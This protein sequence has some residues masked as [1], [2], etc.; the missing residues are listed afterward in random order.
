M[1]N[2]VLPAIFLLLL[3]LPIMLTAVTTTILAA[4]PTGDF[5][6]A[7][8]VCSPVP[9]PKHQWEDKNEVTH[10]RG[11]PGV[12]TFTSCNIEGMVGATIEFIENADMDK[13]YS[14]NSRV[15]G[16]ITLV[17]EDSPSYRIQI[18]FTFAADI[19]GYFMIV[20]KGERMVGTC[21][22]VCEVGAPIVLTS[23]WYHK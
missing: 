8:M 16:T 14:G 12:G 9:P 23:T 21:S 17:N 20:G 4:P 13:D 19:T 11:M 6:E 3:T 22:G 18:Y 5:F 15:W 1:Q 10:Y 7:T 2:R